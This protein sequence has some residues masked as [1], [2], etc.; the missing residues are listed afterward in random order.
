MLGHAVCM[1]PCGEA[2]S[3][4]ILH[5]VPVNPNL[6][7]EHTLMLYPPGLP[8]WSLEHSKLHGILFLTRCKKLL[9]P[10][11]FIMANTLWD[12]SHWTMYPCYHTHTYITHYIVLD[13]GI[14]YNLRGKAIKANI[15]V[16]KQV[17]YPFKP[18]HFFWLFIFHKDCLEHCWPGQNQQ[19]LQQ[20]QELHSAKSGHQRSC[21]WC[22]P[23]S[24]C[25]CKGWRSGW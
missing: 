3:W 13:V 11:P 7:Q 24:H 15:I 18:K 25:W 6:N 17:V 12:S 10:K 14:E 16:L 22:R 1:K 2:A 23:C 21:S 19:I 5:K 4:L 20:T 9:W 8:V